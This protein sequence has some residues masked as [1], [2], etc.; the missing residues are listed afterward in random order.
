MNQ[1]E[2]VQYIHEAYWEDIDEAVHG[3]AWFREA[4]GGYQRPPY[5][6]IAREAAARHRKERKRNPLLPHLLVED[7]RNYMTWAYEDA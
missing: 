4:P 2:K 7:F 5:A 6:R 3:E 1:E